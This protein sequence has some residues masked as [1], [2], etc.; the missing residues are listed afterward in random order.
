MYFTFK[1]EGHG[2]EEGRETRMGAI[3]LITTLPLPKVPTGTP[4]Y[5]TVDMREWLSGS[6][7]DGNHLSDRG[8]VLTISDGG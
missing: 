8:R 5:A 3:T 4:L 6:H 7:S 1:S 2:W